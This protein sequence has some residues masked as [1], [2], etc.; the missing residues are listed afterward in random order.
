MDRLGQTTRNKTM[1]SS[2]WEWF[3]FSQIASNHSN[4]YANVNTDILLF[5]IAY[6]FL[7]SKEVWSFG[8]SLTIFTISLYGKYSMSSILVYGSEFINCLYDWVSHWIIHRY[9]SFKHSESFTNITTVCCSVNSAV[10][11][12]DFR[13]RSKIDKVILCLKKKLHIINLLTE[14]FYESN[15][16]L[17]NDCLSG[18]AGLFSVRL[19]QLTLPHATC[20][21]SH[22]VKNFADTDNM[23]TAK[24]EEGALDMK[25]SLSFQFV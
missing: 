19:V 6:C 14:M 21:F 13:W 25:Q 15:I 11:C 4:E 20:P 8:C 18:L 16:T 17:K 23:L 7:P 10:A 2:S 5:H 12:L 9:D 3:F 22:A 24:T 1:K